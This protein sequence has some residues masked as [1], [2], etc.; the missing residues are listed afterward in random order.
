MSEVV[1]FQNV[2][3]PAR[4][5][6]VPWETWRIDE[7]PTGAG[8]WTTIGTGS[9]GT[10]DPDPSSPAARSFSTANGTALDLWYRAVFVDGDSNESQPTPPLQNSRPAAPTAQFA[11]SDEFAIR[12]GLDLTDDEAIR[13]DALLARASGLIQGEA[14][15]TIVLVEDDVLTMPGTTDERVTLP[16]RPVIAVASVTLDDVAL[17]E[18]ASWYLDRNTLVRRSG[19]SMLPGGLLDEDFTRGFGSPTRTLAVTYTHG[20][21]ADDLPPIVKGICLEAAVRVW[22]NPGAAV[23]EAVGD[24]STRYDSPGGLLLT[25]NEAR[26][27]HRLFGNAAR[28]ITIGG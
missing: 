14:K 13:A 7:A 8:P 16:E 23:Y 22:V 1:S 18:G 17:T 4:F 10:P 9:L 27:L 2:T 15:Q 21:P 12:I 3:P 11:T 26:Q 20:Y 24:T 5:D 28:S 25:A 19:L 6:S